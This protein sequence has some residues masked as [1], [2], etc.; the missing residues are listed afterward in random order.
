MLGH[1][2]KKEVSAHIA[3]NDLPRNL[4]IDFV[5]RKS[6][7]IVGVLSRQAALAVT[8]YLQEFLFTLNSRQKLLP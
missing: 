4:T 5:T 8:S 3:S 6:L 7:G 1:V 2:Q